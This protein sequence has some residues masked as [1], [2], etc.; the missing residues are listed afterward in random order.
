MR[1]LICSA[2]VVRSLKVVPNLGAFCGLGL[3]PTC[4]KLCAV[5]SL[6]LSTSCMQGIVRSSGSAKMFVNA[7]S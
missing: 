7:V 4:D 5:S 6:V 2:E 3:S 1:R